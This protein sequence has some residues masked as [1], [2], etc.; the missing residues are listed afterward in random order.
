REAMTGTILKEYYIWPKLAAAEG[1]D[2]D[3]VRYAALLHDI[4]RH[5]E[6]ISKGYVHHEEKGATES[7]KVLIMFN[8]DEITADKVS[9]CIRMH[10]FRRG[11]KPETIEGKVL[12]DADKL[13]GIGAI[14]IGRAFV[15]AGENGARVHDPYIQV[16]KTYSYTKEDTAYREYLVKLSNIKDRILTATAKNIAIER[17]QFMIDFFD[18]INA[19]C[20]G[21]L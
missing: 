20:K 18:R 4:S 9:D 15:F 11:N 10:R 19:E 14:G 16:D 17:H 1:A 5:D 7:K 13:D 21:D 2:I 8:I 6:D 3:I 12:F